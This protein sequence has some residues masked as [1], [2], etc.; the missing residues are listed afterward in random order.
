MPAGIVAAIARDR[1]AQKYIG[2]WSIHSIRIYD[3]MVANNLRS[4]G[5][6]IGGQREMPEFGDTSWCHTILLCD[7]FRHLIDKTVW[8]SKKNRA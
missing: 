3:E 6:R 8:P 4:I 5:R 7:L 1:R 2:V